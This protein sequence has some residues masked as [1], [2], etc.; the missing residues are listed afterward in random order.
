MKQSSA[1][2]EWI[3]YTNQKPVSGD[4]VTMIVENDWLS[5]MLNDT[6]LGVCFVDKRLIEANIYPVVYING[7]PDEVHLLDGFTRSEKKVERVV[8]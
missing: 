1:N 3:A 4:V 5:F 7:T 8:N 6:N 2:A